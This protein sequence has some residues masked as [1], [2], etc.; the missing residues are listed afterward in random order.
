MVCTLYQHAVSTVQIPCHISLILCS[1][2]AL[3]VSLV[4]CD[5]LCRLVGD[6]LLATAFLSYSGP[7]NQEFR[8]LLLAGWE[9]E[10]QQK[11]IPF[12]KSLNLTNMLVAATTVRTM[13]VLICIVW[14]SI[15]T[16][17]TYALHYHVT[18]HDLYDFHHFS[19]PLFLLFIVTHKAATEV[20][21]CTQL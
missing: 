3:C 8:N 7:F 4:T 14:T 18:F 20:V 5:P 17:I 16:T 12:T 6:V 21:L 19:F 15:K 9:G 10:M 11:G 13:L 2:V 1:N